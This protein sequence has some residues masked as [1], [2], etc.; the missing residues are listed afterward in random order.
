MEGEI[1]NHTAS[2]CTFKNHSHVRDAH[3][4]RI[5]PCLDILK[6]LAGK[7]PILVL[8]SNVPASVVRHDV[9][10]KHPLIRNPT[11][12]QTNES[13]AHLERIISK[14]NAMH[15][16]LVIEVVQNS[17]CNHNVGIFK[18]RV[19][20]NGSRVANDKSPLIAVGPLGKRDIAWVG[21]EPEIFDVG[22][23]LQNLCRT[24]SDIDHF[25]ARSGSGMVSN[26]PPS[27]RVRSND[28]LKKVVQKWHFQPPQQSGVTLH[29]QPAKRR[30]LPGLSTQ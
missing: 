17:D 10:G 27:E 29:V 14:P 18:S 30:M 15:G 25:I 16:I 21:V 11:G 12:I 24:T 20:L 26:D 5:D 6:N 4:L 3:C 13:T 8:R 7:L 22:Q 9:P 2:L 28:I 23:T 1:S 19:P